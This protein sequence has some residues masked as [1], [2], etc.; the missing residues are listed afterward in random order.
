MCLCIY[1]VSWST[2]HRLQMIHPPTGS[3]HKEGEDQARECN[4]K[5]PKSE[6]AEDRGIFRW[7]RKLSVQLVCLWKAGRTEHFYQNP[8]K[9]QTDQK[10]AQNRPNILVTSREGKKDETAFS[11]K[12]VTKKAKS[13]SSYIT[14]QCTSSWKGYRTK[15]RQRQIVCVQRDVM[16][17]WSIS[18]IRTVRS[19]ETAAETEL[20][21]ES[22]H[23][24]HTHTRSLCRS[25]PVFSVWRPWW[26]GSLL[27]AP[28]H[29]QML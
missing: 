9:R 23:R 20:T 16:V 6:S 5:I 15:E 10:R 12:E 24:M 25:G 19:T 3:R 26:A 17:A 27:E 4:L 11:V 14:N 8:A 2:G 29:T 13:I 1:G 28:T 21:T 18:Q 7:R 22:T